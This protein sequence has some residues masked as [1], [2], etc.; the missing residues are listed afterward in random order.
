MSI[1]MVFVKRHLKKIIIAVVL[2]IITFGFVWLYKY[3]KG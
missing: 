3:R 1:I 2:T